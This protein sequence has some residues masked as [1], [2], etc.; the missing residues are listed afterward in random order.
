MDFILVQDGQVFQNCPGNTGAFTV[1]SDSEGR[2]RILR[3]NR[4]HSNQ[5]FFPGETQLGQ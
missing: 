3:F 1:S 4:C 5:Q 2:D